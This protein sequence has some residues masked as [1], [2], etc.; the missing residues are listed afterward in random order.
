MENG[1]SGMYVLPD[2]DA[3]LPE[4]E[5]ISASLSI[6]LRREQAG[7]QPFLRLGENGLSLCRESLSVRGD[8]ARLR[9]RIAGRN[10]SSEAIVRA[11]K[12]R[13]RA[14]GLCVDATAGLGE[15]SFLL[16]AAGFSVILYERDPVIAVLLGDALERAAKD[17]GLSEIAGR[18]T[19]WREDS[20]PHLLACSDS[21]D[22]VY[23]DPM[24]PRRN[25]SGGVK[26]KLQLIR[27]LEE[28]GEDERLFSASLAAHPKKVVVKRPAKGPTLAGREPSYVI[29]GSTVRYDVYCPG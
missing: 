23:L 27:A 14:E 11:A 15:D 6:P 8:F 19:L 21:P 12:G 24:F 17:P 5:E 28:P 7:T 10:L 26:K 20:V 29:P 25:G 2:G 9:K 3:F 13:G 1:Q 4:A 16:A 22:L 18:M